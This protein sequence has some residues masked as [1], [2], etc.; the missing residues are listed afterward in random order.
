M[1]GSCETPARAIGGVEE[2]INQ[3]SLV[4]DSLQGR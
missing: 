3:I 4:S 1:D 2:R